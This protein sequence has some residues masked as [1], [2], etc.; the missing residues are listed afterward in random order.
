MSGADPWTGSNNEGKFFSGFIL[1]EGAIP[2]V[3][4]QAGPKSDKMSPNKFE[5]TT[6][7]N[8]SGLR[9][10]CAQSISI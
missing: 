1:P 2:I 8:F 9:T 5:A 6:T 7:L 10:K 4:V 3:P